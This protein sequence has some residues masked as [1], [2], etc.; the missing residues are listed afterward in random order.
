[1]RFLAVGMTLAGLVP[2]VLFL[3][4]HRPARPF[5]WQAVNASG[6][7]WIIALL[8]ARSLLVLLLRGAAPATQGPLDTLVVYGA[9]FGIDALLWYRVATFLRY[10]RRAEQTA[11]PG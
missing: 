6:W 1:M 7:V 4:L 8:Y 9:G 11:P 10:R 3:L 2:A 5:R